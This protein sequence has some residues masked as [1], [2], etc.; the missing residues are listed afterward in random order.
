MADKVIVS[1]NKLTAI[2]DAL[3]AR[4]EKNDNFT[5]DQMASEIN[6]IDIG[7]NTSDATATS[8]DM[9]LGKT[10]YVNDQKITGT[11]ETYD[12][13]GN[14]GNLAEK[15]YTDLLTGTITEFTVPENL[16]TLT[17]YILAKKDNLL[18][19]DL[20]TIEKVP[21]GCC[22]SCNNL[23]TVIFNSETTEIGANAFENCSKL[24]EVKIPK[25]LTKVGNRAFY[26]YNTNEPFEVIL[27]KDCEVGE[28]AFRSTEISKVEG[29]FTTVGDS[30][31]SSKAFGNALKEVIIHNV[32]DC[33]RNFFESNDGVESFY[34]NPE[35]NITSTSLSGFFR[36]FG[37]L[38]TNTEY[39]VFNLLNSSFKELTS[40]SFS[41]GNPNKNKNMRIYLPSTLEKLNST[42]L[43][44]TNNLKVYLTSTPT[45]SSTTVLSNLSKYKIY[46][47]LEDVNILRNMTNWITHS[48]NIYGYV[49]GNEFTVGQS[50]PKYTKIEGL[51]LTWYSDEDISIPLDNLNI[52]EENINNT[53]YSVVGDVRKVYSIETLYTLD[54]DVT[55]SDG[56]NTYLKND[57]I[58]VG[59]EITI[60][61]SPTS[62][63][64][65][66]FYSLYINGERLNTNTFTTTMDSDI[67][68]VASYYDG[69]TE[70][71]IPEL[72]YNSFDVIAK[73]CREGKNTEYWILGD[74]FPLTLTNGDTVTVRYCDDL[75][76]RYEYSDGSG[77]TNAVFEIVELIRKDSSTTAFAW[78]IQ[79]NVDDEGMRENYSI[80][81]I[82]DTLNSGDIWNLISEEFRAILKPVNI[83]SVKNSKPE[84]EIVITS[85]CLFLPLLKEIDEKHSTQADP[86][87]LEDTIYKSPFALYNN[88]D[89]NAFRKKYSIGSTSAK[90]WGLRSVRTT[91]YWN[92]FVLVNINSQGVAFNN[93][94]SG[95]ALISIS[96]FFAL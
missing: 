30:A 58:P 47:K 42:C 8:S 36:D 55:I 34:I 21:D 28:Y 95:D 79:G 38:R 63:N 29:H 19:V 54:C 6:S 31:F 82:R 33:P 39:F 75:E 20:S 69:V 96:P 40:Y 35:V 13:E 1:K 41:G 43:S 4:T 12:Y 23:E 67:S 5:L 68:I 73:T 59:T 72:K 83:P 11:I 27:D 86:H 76:G 17:P 56:I 87:P 32:V 90:A 64:K 14:E 94:Y 57:F 74:T 2:G 3:R 85:D 15:A 22:Y 80:S 16:E 93:S 89:T 50:L 77:S 10:A 78:N 46:A 61:V 84:S 81:T 92:Q 7:I 9:L 70:P 45:I 18:R 26:N 91:T 48:Q 53:F 52:T 65:N 66:I 51:E 25:N 71:I 88:N 24:K 49:F 60:T 44:Y 37:T 62:E